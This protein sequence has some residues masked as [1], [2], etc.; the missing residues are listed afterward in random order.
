MQTIETVCTY[1]EIEK[2]IAVIC[3]IQD[4]YLLTKIQLTMEKT[5]SN[6]VGLAHILFL[7]LCT[8]ELS[9]MY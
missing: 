5:L 7:Y 4:Y 3:E 2:S 6:T 1:T 8:H 9:G